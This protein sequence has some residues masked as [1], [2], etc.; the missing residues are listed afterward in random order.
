VSVPAE[1]EPCPD[2][3][4]VT[5]IGA[6]DADGDAYRRCGEC[7]YVQQIRGFAGS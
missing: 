6:V 4:G 5:S 1:D 3:D 7:G 2:C